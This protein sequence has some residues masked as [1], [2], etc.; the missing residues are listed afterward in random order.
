MKKTLS[1]ALFLSCL[2]CMPA[3]PATQVYKCVSSN[4]PI[5]FSDTDCPTNTQQSIHNVLQPMLIPAPSKHVIK[6]HAQKRAKQKNQTRVTVIGDQSHP[7]GTYNPQA[8]RTAMV[9]KQV[10][11][12]MSL[13]DIESMYG[14]PIKSSTSNG[15]LSAT[16]RSPK[17]Q[18]RNVRFD[19][20]GC[21][22]SKQKSGSTRT[23]KKK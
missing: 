20:H 4:G 13:A 17:G 7:C 12:G 8:R 6:S 9:R 14:K 23:H 5:I 19:E 21:V 22:R 2:H 1:S 3:H 10:K 11:S 15:I 18:K 16:Y